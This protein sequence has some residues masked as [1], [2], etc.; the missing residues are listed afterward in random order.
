MGL[1]RA[2]EYE[3][4]VEAPAPDGADHTLVDGVG[5]TGLDR[6]LDDGRHSTARDAVYLVSRSR[7]MY[8]TAVA[9]SAR[10]IERLQ[11]C[12]V[13]QPETHG[14]EKAGDLGAACHGGGG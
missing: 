10:S 12:W 11:A 6:G 9:S 2:A 3:Q 5:P 14:R 8:L 7:K 4:P 1:P 13:T